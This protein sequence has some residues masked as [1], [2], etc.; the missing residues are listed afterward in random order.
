MNFLTTL[1]ELI[2]KLHNDG[3]PEE[4]YLKALKMISEK[5][6]D[7][8]LRKDL[9]DIST[10]VLNK[11]MKKLELEGIL[12]NLL[13]WKGVVEK[14]NSKNLRK[15][16]KILKRDFVEAEEANNQVR[17]RIKSNVKESPNLDRFTPVKRSS[18]LDVE[19]DKK[20]KQSAVEVLTSDSFM[21]K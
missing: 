19:S 12:K 17:K 13:T 20:R 15:G 16:R 5:K 3:V 18:I 7:Y 14:P 8:L 11:L 21:R 10:H 2:S 9:P 6:D 4:V 1:L